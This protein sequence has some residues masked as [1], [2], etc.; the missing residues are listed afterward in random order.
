MTGPKLNEATRVAGI[1]S[2]FRASTRFARL[3]PS[4]VRVVL[5]LVRGM[6]VKSA[7]DLLRLTD[8]DSAHIIRKLLASAVA[9][10]TN[11]FE[12]NAEELYIKA[13]FADAGP[14]L[15]RFRPRAKGS[16]AA[17]FKRTSHIAIVVDKLSDAALA[18][19]ETQ[20]E[21]RG[22]AESARRRDRVE[23]SRARSQKSKAA[24][25]DADANADAPVDAE[26][27]TATEN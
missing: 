4:K 24:A 10:A 1:S 3:S 18:I 12:Q 22:G 15:K 13:C 14:T 11:N 9:N 16:S 23:A 27:E 25:P 2:G 8:R 26:T 5:N 6:D 7:D 21:S 17:I 20:S 19:R